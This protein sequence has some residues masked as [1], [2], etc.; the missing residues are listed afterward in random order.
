MVI[1]SNLQTV[2]AIY[3]AFGKG[4]VPTILS[5]VADDVQWESWAD[6]SSQKAGTPWMKARQGKDE[7]GVFFQ[8]IGALMIHDFQLL[9]LMEGG[10]QIAAEFIIEFTDPISGKRLRDEEMHLWTFNDEGKIS[11]LRHYTDTHKHM[12]AAGLL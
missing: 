6:N 2:Q 7:V 10:N 1:T 3:E 5:H 4:D 12:M 9:S 8:T 11:R